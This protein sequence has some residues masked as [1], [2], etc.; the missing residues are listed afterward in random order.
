MKTPAEKNEPV[1]PDIEC[2]G[3]P[4]RDACRQ[5][6][7]I[8]RRGSLTPISLSLASIMVFL[9]PIITAI[10]AGTLAGSYTT[11]AEYP[12]LWQV[13]GGAAGFIVGV[14]LARLIMPLIRKRFDEHGS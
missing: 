3:C 7:G 9:F 8:S 11:D 6:W 4:S 2:Q 13:V 1:H 14:L 10:S 5:V 12:I